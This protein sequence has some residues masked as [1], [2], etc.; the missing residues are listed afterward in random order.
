MVFSSE[1]DRPLL[2]AVSNT[3][4]TGTRLYQPYLFY[5]NKLTVAVVDDGI[6]IESRAHRARL[7]KARCCSQWR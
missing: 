1:M 2:S 6:D 3:A 5:E 7:Q 4:Q